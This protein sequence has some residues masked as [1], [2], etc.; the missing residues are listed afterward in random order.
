MP[1]HE[2]TLADDGFGAP[3]PPRRKTPLIIAALGVL[4]VLALL[5]VLF[6][7]DA[8]GGNA[9]DYAVT[10]EVFDTAS[11]QRLAVQTFEVHGTT[12]FGGTTAA[13]APLGPDGIECEITKVS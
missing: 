12:T 1:T 6:V 5:A 3:R 13:Q 11:R 9:A 4:G 8:P 10:V 7:D 2:W